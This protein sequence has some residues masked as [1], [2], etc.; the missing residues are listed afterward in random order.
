MNVKIFFYLNRKEVIY[1]NCGKSFER[2]ISHIK[3][4][5]KQFCSVECCN[6]YFSLIN[7]EKRKCIV[8][9]KSFETKKSS[10]KKDVFC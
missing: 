1:S 8:C 9:G 3:R 2:K 10:K 6:Q 7:K 4:H 5:E